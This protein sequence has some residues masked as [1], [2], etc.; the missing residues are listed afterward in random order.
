MYGVIIE[1]LKS[2]I[3]KK[4]I[5]SEYIKRKMWLNSRKMKENR[6]LTTI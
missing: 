5:N 6:T 2:R 4:C 1:N 3:N